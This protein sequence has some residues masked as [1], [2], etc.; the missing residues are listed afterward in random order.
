MMKS[1]EVLMKNDLE[2]LK[3]AI[4]EGLVRNGFKDKVIDMFAAINDKKEC[5]KLE[6]EFLDVC[7]DINNFYPLYRK[8][9]SFRYDTEEF[10]SIAIKEGWAALDNYCILEDLDNLLLDTDECFV[11]IKEYLLTC[12][13]KVSLSQKEKECIVLEK[14]INNKLKNIELHKRSI[15][16]SEDKIETLKKK[17][18]ALKKGK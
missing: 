9:I 5:N 13:Q 6:K 16:E 15:K 2:Q 10:L 11:L 7:E 12:L 14:Q 1:V 3:L 8:L 18:E 17:M 4:E